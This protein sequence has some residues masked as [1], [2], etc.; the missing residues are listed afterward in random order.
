MSDFERVKRAG[1]RGD[2]KAENVA[3]SLRATGWK[4]APPGSDPRMF[5]DDPDGIWLGL[6]K[7]QPKPG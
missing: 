4:D 6:P 2:P 3:K 7:P 5:A 1:K